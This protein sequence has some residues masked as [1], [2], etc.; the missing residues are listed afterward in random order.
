MVR[1]GPRFDRPRLINRTVV[2]TRSAVDLIEKSTSRW[3]TRS[4]TECGLNLLYLYLAWVYT[5]PINL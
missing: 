2:G 4:I 5:S 3:Y 1:G